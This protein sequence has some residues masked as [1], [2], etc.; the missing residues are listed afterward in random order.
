M[1]TKQHALYKRMSNPFFFR[2]FTRKMVPAAASAGVRFC[3][4]SDTSC[5]IIVPNKGKN[6]NPFKS[7]YFAVQ[8][9]G[10]E[11][12]TA[13]PIMFHLQAYEAS[14]AWIVTHFEVDFPSKAVGDVVFECKQV[15]EIKQA[16]QEAANSTDSIEIKLKTTG[17]MA[18]GKVVSNFVFTWSLRKRI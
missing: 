7:M 18:D 9:M 13:L 2:L 8:S 5:K 14:I 16:V 11:M 1:N 12:S 4:L 17:R 6:R 3:E 10:A 15:G